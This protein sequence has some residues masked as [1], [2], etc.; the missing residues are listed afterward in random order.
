MADKNLAVV[1]AGG[2]G[3]I[4]DITIRPGTTAQDILREIDLE[5]YVLSKGNEAPFG[6]NENVYPLVQDGDKLYASTPAEA[7]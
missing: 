4:K 1:V 5:G 7:G 3:D 2:A 6:E